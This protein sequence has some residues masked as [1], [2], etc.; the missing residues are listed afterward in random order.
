MMAEWEFYGRHT[1][2]LDLARRLQIHP[3]QP[4]RRTKPARFA[5]IGIGGRRG[6]GK[7]ALLEH[8]AQQHGWQDRLLIV[9]LNDGL[10]KKE[11]G[12]QEI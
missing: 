3:D 12:D 5:A 10:H 6:I 9:T 8:V 11:T 2:S 4:Y 7:N 1:A